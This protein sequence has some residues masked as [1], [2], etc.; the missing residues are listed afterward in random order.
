M[1]AMEH[2]LAT[3]RVDHKAIRHKLGMVARRQDMVVLQLAMV[4]LRQVMELATVLGMQRLAMEQ[5]VMVLLV[6]ATMHIPK[7]VNPDMMHTAREG[8]MHIRRD[9]LLQLVMEDALVGMRMAREHLALATTHGMVVEKALATMH[10][11]RDMMR[12]AKAVHLDTMDIAKV[13]QLATMLI[14][15]VHSVARVVALLVLCHPRRQSDREVDR[16]CEMQLKTRA[17]RLRKHNLANLWTA[18]KELSATID[19]RG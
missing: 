13:V 1:A 2:I 12:I 7:A 11:P 14:P 18:T 10:F 15:R 17:S 6:A 19:L 4:A 3:D 8:T 16:R 9:V 5:G